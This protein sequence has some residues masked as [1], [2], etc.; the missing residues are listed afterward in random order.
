[1]A[2]SRKY[3]MSKR[4]L[5][6]RIKAGGNILRKAIEHKCLK[7]TRGHNVHNLTNFDEHPGI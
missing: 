3:V 5:W 4:I 1:M 7:G 2:K 6:T